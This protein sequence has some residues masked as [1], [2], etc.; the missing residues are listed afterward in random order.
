MT[1][2]LAGTNGDVAYAFSY[3]P[4]S[5]I[6][7]RTRS[8]DAYVFDQEVNVSRGYLVNGLNQYTNAGALTLAYDAN[9][10]LTSDGSPS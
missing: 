8:N 10:S 1:D 9:G 4:A 3:N 5:Q 7:G 6:V 2:N